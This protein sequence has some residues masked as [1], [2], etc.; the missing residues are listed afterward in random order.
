MG[1]R[2][3]GRHL[4]RDV[5]AHYAGQRAVVGAALP[6]VQVQVVQRAGP[7]AQHD[8]AGR[9]FRVGA[10]AV[11]QL[12][13]AAVLVD[14]YCLHPFTSPIISSFGLKGCRLEI[15]LRLESLQYDGIA[16]MILKGKTSV[17]V[18]FDCDRD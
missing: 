6:Q 3:D 13:G 16:E 14:K 1:R 7:D 18:P 5:A 2:A 12:V 9:R 17:K 11:H 15:R 10:V 4:A 8:L